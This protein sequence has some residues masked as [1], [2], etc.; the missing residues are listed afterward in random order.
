MQPIDPPPPEYSPTNPPASPPLNPIDPPDHS[1]GDPPDVP[2]RETDLPPWV[3]P[4]D[5][6]NVVD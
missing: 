1:P 3:Q 4:P 5:R 2:V 6:S